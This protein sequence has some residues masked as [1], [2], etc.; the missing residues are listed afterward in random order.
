MRRTR[1]INI[2]IWIEYLFTVSNFALK[3]I[4]GVHTNNEFHFFFRCLD[5]NS[6]HEIN[7]DIFCV[8]SL[9]LRSSWKQYQPC[10]ETMPCNIRICEQ[11]KQINNI[12]WTLIPFKQIKLNLF[13]QLPR[14]SS[15]LFVF[16][17]LGL[18]SVCS[19]VQIHSHTN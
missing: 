2:H 19:D 3:C 10:Q 14:I 18:S 1:E 6:F 4:F 16:V 17:C 7:F 8:C 15:L 13:K 11:T 5:R 9:G 12:Y